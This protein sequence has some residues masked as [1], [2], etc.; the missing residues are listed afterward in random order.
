MNIGAL[1]R[2]V[3]ADVAEKALEGVVA[4]RSRRNADVQVASN[5]CVQQVPL[6]S[7]GPAWVTRIAFACIIGSVP[8]PV[9]PVGDGRVT[10]A[11]CGGISRDIDGSLIPDISVC[12]R[13]SRLLGK[14]QGVRNETGNGG[15]H[16]SRCRNPEPEPR[17]AKWDEVEF[18]SL[19]VRKGQIRGDEQRRY[20]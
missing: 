20:L 7:A 2:I 11:V 5:S 18:P 12:R 8:P 17:M 14:Q 13:S 9:G 10:E 19:A 15:P 4:R 6:E 1:S 16:C 3:G